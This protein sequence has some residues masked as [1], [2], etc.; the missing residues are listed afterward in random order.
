MEAN[1]LA[2]TNTIKPCD[3]VYNDDDD[4]GGGFQ[5]MTH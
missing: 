3:G 5:L 4:G 1:E 2:K